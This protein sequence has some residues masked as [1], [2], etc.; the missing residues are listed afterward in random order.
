ML[1]DGFVEGASAGR[2]YLGNGCEAGETVQLTEFASTPGGA[3]PILMRW[4]RIRR[5]SSGSYTSRFEQSTTYWSHR[6]CV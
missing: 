2:T 1:V 5:M 4:R 6:I 3:L